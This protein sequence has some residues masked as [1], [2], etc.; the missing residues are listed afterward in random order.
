M[1]MQTRDVS[2]KQTQLNIRRMKWLGAVV[3]REVVTIKMRKMDD[4]RPTT[5]ADVSISLLTSES[6][7]PVDPLTIALCWD[8][9]ES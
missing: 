3:I 6:G 1:T 7:M 2:G 8:F 9:A 4:P 5:R